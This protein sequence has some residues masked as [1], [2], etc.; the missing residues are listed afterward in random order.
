MK[1]KPFR[2]THPN[3]FWALGVGSQFYARDLGGLTDRPF[4]VGICV[5]R[6]NSGPGTFDLDT[7]RV[8]SK[9]PTQKQVKVDRWPLSCSG[10]EFMRSAD[11]HI[12]PEPGGHYPGVLPLGIVSLTNPSSAQL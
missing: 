9:A 1:M 7:Y 3:S 8:D 5:T 10:S 4:A 2:P 11:R 6:T 12:P